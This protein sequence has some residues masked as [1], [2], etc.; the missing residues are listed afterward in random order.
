MIKILKMLIGSNSNKQVYMENIN[1][2][3]NRCLQFLRSS[4]ETYKDIPYCGI[5]HETFKLSIIHL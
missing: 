5:I 3:Q 2:Q 1:K 4:L